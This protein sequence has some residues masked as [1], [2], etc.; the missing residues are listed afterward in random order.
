MN[1]EIII[2]VIAAIIGSNA[3]W[4]FVQF[5][6]TRKD[7][8][9]GKYKEIIDMLGKL[10]EEIENI[11]AKAEEREA[12]TARVRIL[13]F[14]DDLLENKRHSKDSFDQVNTDITTYESYCKD[15]PKF[16]N[17]QTKSTIEYINKVYQDR[18][19]KHDFL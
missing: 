9:N 1:I 6:F 2:T 19:E 10:Q 16:K 8:K 11:E 14:M 5:L 12:V 17:N 3:L 7:E 13:R 4:G 15:H 18:L